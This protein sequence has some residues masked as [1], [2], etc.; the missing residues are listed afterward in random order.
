MSTDTDGSSPG[1]VQSVDRAVSILEYLARHGWSGVTDVGNDLGVHKSTAFRLL[2]TLESRGLVEQHVDSG[3]YH[4]GFGLVHLARAVSVGPDLTR[5][6]QPSCQWL[7]EK[8]SETVT[9]AVLEGAESVTVDQII[10]DA[11]VVS[12]SWL[13]RRTP[14]HC[15]SAGK[16]FLAWLPTSRTDVIVAGPHERFT[17][18]TVV[19]PVGLRETIARVR[20]DGYAIAYEEFEE[21]LASVAAPIYAADGTVVA[22]VG[23]SGPAYRLSFDQLVDISSLVRQAAQQTSARYG[24]ARREQVEADG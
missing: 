5:Q 6:A 9:L 22:A 18:N 24:F 19:D 1:H 2:S 15:T 14:L 17:D 12:R 21:G 11:S 13:G 4:L 20:D 16:V 10:P 23:V 7:A 8:T 3:K